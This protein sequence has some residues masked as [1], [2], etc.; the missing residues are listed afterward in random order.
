[1]GLPDLDLTVQVRS[2]YLGFWPAGKRSP[3]TRT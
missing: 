3:A 1:L 2:G